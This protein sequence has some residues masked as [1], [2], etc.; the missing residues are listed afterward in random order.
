LCFA[1]GEAGFAV[2]ELGLG[3]TIERAQQGIVYAD[4]K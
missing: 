3:L 2:R 1:G 4:L